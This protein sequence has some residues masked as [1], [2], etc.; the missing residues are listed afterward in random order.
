MNADILQIC[1]GG[2][3]KYICAK[4]GSNLWGE[5]EARVACYQMGMVWQEGSG[6][7]DVL[8]SLIKRFILYS[9]IGLKTAWTNSNK[10]LHKNFSCS[11]LEEKLINCSSDDQTFCYCYYWINNHKRYAYA[12]AKCKEG[13]LY[14]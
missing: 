10:F 14:K 6:I 11:G 8:I 13:I 12:T 9:D 5:N 2:Q 3:W 4:P 1:S 7:V